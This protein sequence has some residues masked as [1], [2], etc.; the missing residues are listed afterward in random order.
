MR[1]DPVNWATG[2]GGGVAIARSGR[3]SI[4]AVA[5]EVSGRVWP[6]KTKARIGVSRRNLPWTLTVTVEPAASEQV[7]GLQLMSMSA[8]LIAII[9][10]ADSSWTRQTTR[11]VASLQG[12]P[13]TYRSGV[14]AAWNA[15]SR[16]A[17]FRVMFA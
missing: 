5:V 12:W 11:F 8:G 14:F 1:G 15:P 16:A 17:L 3:Y 4:W 10:P 7:P 2:A 6:P 9:E 13:E